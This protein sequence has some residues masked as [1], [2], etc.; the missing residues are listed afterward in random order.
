MKSMLIEI[1]DLHG[2]EGLWK[3]SQDHPV[4]FWRMASRLIP[5]AKEFSGPGGRPIQT[6]AIQAVPRTQDLRRVVGRWQ[7]RRESQK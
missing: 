4:E 3:F 6:L 2:V 7:G 5:I 1:V